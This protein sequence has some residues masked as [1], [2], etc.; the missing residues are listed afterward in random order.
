MTYQKRDKLDPPDYY[1]LALL[2]VILDAQGNATYRLDWGAG[3]PVAIFS[4]RGLSGAK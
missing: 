3:L 4:W 2:F 1:L